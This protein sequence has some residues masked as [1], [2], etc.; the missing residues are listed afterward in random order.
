MT[1]CG[2]ERLMREVRGAFE[3]FG[4][5]GHSVALVSV[6]DAPLACAAG[7]VSVLATVDGLMGWELSAGPIFHRR[8][9][10]L[11]RQAPH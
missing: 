1:N 9:L 2:V 6:T 7:G 5:L 4:L 11:R 3:E 8:G 10:V